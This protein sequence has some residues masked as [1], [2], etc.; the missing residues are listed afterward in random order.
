MQRDGAGSVFDDV[1][2]ESEAGQRVD[3]VDDAVA[4]QVLGWLGNRSKELSFMVSLVFF[5]QRTS[6]RT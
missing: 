5:V 2:A 3:Q 6:R 4:A 1:R